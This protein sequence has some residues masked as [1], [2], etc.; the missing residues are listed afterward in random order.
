MNS[1]ISSMSR[2]SLSGYSSFSSAYS[3]S[4]RKIF[5]YLPKGAG[6]FSL[7]P[8]SWF[9]F[10]WFIVSWL[11]VGFPSNAKVGFPAVWRSYGRKTVPLEFAALLHKGGSVRKSPGVP[12]AALPCVRWPFHVGKQRHFR[13]PQRID[14]DMHMNVAAVV[15]PVW[16]GAYKGLA[17]GEMLFTELLA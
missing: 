7:A 11:G 16:V 4:E 14:Y 13:N 2:S 9:S 3:L 10:S 1:L 6:G 5:L 15:M 8:F 12:S 17:S